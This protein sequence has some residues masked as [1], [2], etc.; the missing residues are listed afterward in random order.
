[1]DRSRT[2]ARICQA[3]AADDSA[4]ASRIARKDY[5]FEPVIP[6]KRKHTPYQLTRLFIRDG[7]VDRYSGDR[8][9]FPGALGILTQRLPDEFPKHKNWKMDATHM[10]YWELYPTVDHLVPVARGGTNDQDNLVTTSMIRNSA[11]SNWTLAELGWKLVSP[12]D[13]RR[14]DGMLS[15]FLGY[16]ENDVSILQ[17]KYIKPWHGAAVRACSAG[18]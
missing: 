1:M 5:P 16:V 10:A 9:V 6:E 8:L 17:N 14:W 4:T 2:I 13:I 7:F 11:K 18:E 3:L 12:G 15:W